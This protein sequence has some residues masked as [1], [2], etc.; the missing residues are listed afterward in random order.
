[1]TARRGK[2]RLPLLLSVVQLALACVPFLAFGNMALLGGLVFLWA[3][4][5]IAK[6]H[7]AILMLFKMEN[8]D[9][10]GGNLVWAREKLALQIVF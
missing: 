7:V 3:N 8:R 9:F 5:H 6:Q 4:Y 2:A 10:S 1:L